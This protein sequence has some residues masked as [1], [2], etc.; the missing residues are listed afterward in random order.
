M[1]S[2]ETIADYSGYVETGSEA[3]PASCKM[4]TGGFPWGGNAAGA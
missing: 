1:L 2:M 3:H 4:S